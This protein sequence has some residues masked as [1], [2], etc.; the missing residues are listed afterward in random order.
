MP[1]INGVKRLFAELVASEAH[2]GQVGGDSDTVSATPTITAG[3]Y[4]AEDIVGGVQTLTDAA[5]VAGKEVVLESIV[6]TD[7]AKQNAAFDIFFFDRE[8]TNGTYTDNVALD[9]DDADMAFCIG[10]VSLSGYANSADSSVGALR[11]IGLGLSPNA[12][13]LYAIAKCTGT[14]TYASTSDLTFKYFFLRD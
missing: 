11:N 12:S 2:I 1:I 8:P 3:A 6:I 5:R 7:L 9:I 14:P 4:S 13:N 10:Y